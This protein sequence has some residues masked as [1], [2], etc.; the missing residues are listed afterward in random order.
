MSAGGERCGTCPND[1][2]H[3]VFYE[4]E[5]VGKRCDDCMEALEKRARMGNIVGSDDPLD[6]I[7]M[8]FFRGHLGEA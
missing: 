5:M 1:A 8:T 4:G 7:A 6:A 2:T 3:T